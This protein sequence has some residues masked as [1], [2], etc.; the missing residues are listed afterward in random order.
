MILSIIDYL[1]RN[2]KVMYTFLVLYLLVAFLLFRKLNK[3]GFLLVAFF[4]A[5]KVA[6][7]DYIE[8]YIDEN[9]KLRNFKSEHIFGVTILVSLLISLPAILIST[10]VGLQED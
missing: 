10:K 5:L 8:K 7:H 4:V 9:K 6:V 2:V 3:L 1:L